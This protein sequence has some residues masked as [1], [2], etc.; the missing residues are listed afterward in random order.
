M[1]TSYDVI[2]IGAG[3]GGLSCALHLAERGAKVL[4]CETLKYPGGCASTFSRGRFKFESG[5]TL[6]AGFAPGQLFHQWNERYS[7]GLKTTPLNP[8]VELRAPSLKLPIPSNREE[9][10]ALLQSMGAP[11]GLAGFF[12]LQEKVADALWGLFSDPSLLPPFNASNLMRHLAR[13]PKYLVMLRLIGR[14]LESVLARF[15]LENFAP[16]RVYLNALCQITVQTSLDRA[17]APFA[18]AIMDYYFRGAHHIHNGVGALAK[19]L[20]RAIEEKGGQV[21]LT[22][23]VRRLETQKDHVVVSTRRGDFIAKKIAANLLPQNLQE[24]TG[25]ST[26]NLQELSQKVEVGYSAVMLYLAL[27]H[28]EIP[29]AHHLELIADTD[30]PFIEGNHIFCSVSAADEV[31]GPNKERTVTIS[32]HIPL[33]R[34]LPERPLVE[35]IQA[36]MKATLQQLA[37]EI[38]EKII[39]DMTASPRTFERF[40][41]RKFGYV[42]GIPR[43]KGLSHYMSMSPREALPHIYLVGDSIFPGQSMLATA[44]GGLKTAEV[45]HRALS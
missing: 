37:P 12:R 31:R 30:K 4:V 27:S 26:P 17:E 28:F 38:T 22:N 29:H 5:A 24:L 41:G 3:F 32:T 1:T 43:V 25:A 6:A 19:S 7:L 18:L 21:M 39:F 42:G 15:G 9:L 44:L 8:V 10:L 2:V 16:L 13:S 36:R 45:I 34:G 20:V 23:P 40:T 11:G 14:S 33:Q 35:E